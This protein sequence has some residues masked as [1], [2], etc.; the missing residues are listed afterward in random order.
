M[1]IMQTGMDSS[2]TACPEVSRD[3][4]RFSGLMILGLNFVILL[5]YSL[6]SQDG[7][8][9][10]IHNQ[11]RRREGRIQLFPTKGE[12]GKDTSWLSLSILRNM[13]RRIGMGMVFPCHK[14]LS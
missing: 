3:S 8:S 13:T 5:I 14:L 11:V 6:L 7:Y 1:L 12:A 10:Y 9:H 2:H 4:D